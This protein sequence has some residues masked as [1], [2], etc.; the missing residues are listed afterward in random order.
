M[1]TIVSDW[2]KACERAGARLAKT[3]VEIALLYEMEPDSIDEL[4][5]IAIKDV[6][7][8]LLS[9]GMTPR[10]TEASCNNI[11]RALM[12]EGMR[13]SRTITWEAGHA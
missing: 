9:S 1:T 6:R 11:L 5:D 12:S 2:N 4:V 7:T 10:N 3:V 8:C 13:L